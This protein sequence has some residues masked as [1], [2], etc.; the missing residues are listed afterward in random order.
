MLNPFVFSIARYPHPHLS[1]PVMY[2]LGRLGRRGGQ[3]A[4]HSK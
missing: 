3:L 1:D 4:G 2:R